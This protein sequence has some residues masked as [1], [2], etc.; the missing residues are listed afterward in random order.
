MSVTCVSSCIT[1][2]LMPQKLSKY[3]PFSYWP[4]CAHGCCSQ[5]KK[6]STSWQSCRALHFSLY[7]CLFSTTFHLKPVFWFLHLF[8][9]YHV[10][11]KGL[12]HFYTKECGAK[13]C[14]LLDF[15]FLV[16][17]FS[18]VLLFFSFFIIVINM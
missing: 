14:G 7:C 15:L 18:F 16:F 2:K 1:L 5:T 8:L 6:T 11:L 4:R 10:V 3:V 9:T 17:L 13:R 12:I